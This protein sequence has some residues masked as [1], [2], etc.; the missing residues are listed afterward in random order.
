MIE[1]ILLTSTELVS[2]VLV[3]SGI[4]PFL[5]AGILG[6]DIHSRD[7]DRHTYDER[8]GH[9]QEIY[10]ELEVMNLFFHNSPHEES[11]VEEQSYAADH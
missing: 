11:Y 3:F 1:I 5:T 7:G 8:C 4:Q 2:N 10:F 6:H 9:Q